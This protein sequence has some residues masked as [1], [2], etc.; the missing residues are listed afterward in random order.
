M[1]RHAEPE[2]SA[3][4]RCYGSLDVGLSAAGREQCAG[5]AADLAD[6]PITAVYA[7][8]LLRS[9]E[10]AA[11]IAAAHRLPI[12]IVGEL[13]ELDFGEWEGRRYDEIAET[14]PDLFARWLSAPTTVVPPGGESFRA[15]SRRVASATA[16]IRKEVFGGTGVI[17]THGGVCRALIAAVLQLNE[18]VIFR[19]DIGYVCGLVIDWFEEEPVV[20]LL[21]GRLTDVAGL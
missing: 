4:G 6:V 17:V 2:P 12:V 9:R 14:T 1:I 10:T 15:L 19:I 11:A 16:T 5:L 18:T 21:N 8:P 7:S 3:R 20:R 13:R